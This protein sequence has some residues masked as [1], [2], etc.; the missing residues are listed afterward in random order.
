MP[1]SCWILSWW[2]V[3][4]RSG[5]CRWPR[6]FSQYLPSTWGCF[7]VGSPTSAWSEDRTR[8]SP[9]QMMTVFRSFRPRQSTLP[10]PPAVSALSSP[11]LGHSVWWPFVTLWLAHSLRLPA[12]NLG[13]ELSTTFLFLA[14]N[15]ILTSTGC[16]T[17]INK[18]WYKMSPYVALQFWHSSGGTEKTTETSK[19]IA[20]RRGRDLNP[21][22]PK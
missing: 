1:I 6:L 9:F 19:R 17:V 4:C 22:P 11:F 2:L 8:V 12:P 5:S 3:R 14:A 15:S 18:D 7:S 10:L 21:S 20:G 16:G 13:A